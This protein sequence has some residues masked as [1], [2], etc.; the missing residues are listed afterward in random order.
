MV[1]CE[2]FEVKSVGRQSASF[3]N[4]GWTDAYAQAP[5]FLKALFRVDNVLADVGLV[6]RLEMG[7]ATT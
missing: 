6:A 3:A 2:F 7:T 1:W 4:I 5:S